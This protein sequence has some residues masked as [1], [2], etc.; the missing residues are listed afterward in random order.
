MIVPFDEQGL[1]RACEL[2]CAG[3]LCAFPTETVYGLGARADRADAVGRIYA[4]KGRPATNPSIVHCA[5]ADSALAHAQEVSPLALQLARAFWPGPLTLVL[6]LRPNLLAA[7]TTAGGSTV[8]LRV[9]NHP[10]A[11]A[12][13][14]EVRL[15]IAAPSANRSTQ[16]SP[17]L[18]E[19]VEKSLGSSVFVL[20]GGATG[21][22]IES[23]IVRVVGSAIEILRRGSIGPIELQEFGAVVDLGTAVTEATSP[24]VAPG[25]TRRHYAP[26]VPAF[27]VD[28]AQ[29]N[30]RNEG[31]S[32][33]LLF[34]DTDSSVGLRGQPIER[35]PREARAYARGLYA[36][37][38][39]LETS[40]AERILIE[41]VPSDP[42]WNAIKDRLFRAT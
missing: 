15:P 36:A 16:L 37:L 35:L 32:G 11:Q 8:A 3:Q 2:L 7:E 20:D 14:R 38:H 13:L 41:A 25:L 31:S 26:A 42:S 21:F 34:A 30:Q 33:L 22:G 29:L 27:L 4:A 39:R 17:T 1:E 23:T 10:M 12:L 9:P 19:H 28:R 24:M 6:P 18:A 5:D 40:G